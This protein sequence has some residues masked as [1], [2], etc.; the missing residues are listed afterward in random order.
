MTDH[1]SPDSGDATRLPDEE[2]SPTDPQLEREL[3][4]EIDLWLA[5]TDRGPGPADR[6]D[7]T[8]RFRELVQQLRAAGQWSPDAHATPAAARRSPSGLRAILR[9]LRPSPSSAALAAGAA[10]VV[11]LVV[12]VVRTDR[13]SASGPGD[14]VVYVARPGQR[15]TVAL[16]NGGRIVLAPG[17]TLRL[18]GRADGAFTSADLV[19]E[20][21]FDVASHPNAPVVVRTGAVQTRVLGTQFT[22]RRYTTDRD[23][24]VAVVSG[25]VEVRGTRPRN[26]GAQAPAIVLS[27]GM[28]GHATDSTASGAM[29]DVKPLTSWVDGSLVFHDAPVSEVLSELGRWYGFTFKV[30]DSTLARGRLSATFDYKTSEEMFAALKILLDVR[31]AFDT[32][33][34]TLYP[35]GQAAGRLLQKSRISTHS[36]VG[37]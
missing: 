17:S 19:G 20:A 6:W 29:A 31:V 2:S 23:T 25:K 28:V 15:T 24:R 26:P 35:R 22:V 7:A 12:G 30:A 5:R 11:A 4:R 13:H 34:V 3:E 33:T 10:A 9:R 37:R 1:L 21:L 16:A 14:S 32:T 8:A 36:E 27:A 18:S